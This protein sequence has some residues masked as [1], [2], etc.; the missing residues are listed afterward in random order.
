MKRMTWVLAIILALIV[1]TPCTASHIVAGEYDLIRRE[2][3]WEASGDYDIVDWLGVGYSLRC[4]CPGYCWKTIIPSWFPHRQDYSV[5]AEAR[6]G[7]WSIRLTDWCN[8]WLAQSDV[9]WWEDTHGLTVRV[10]WR[11][12]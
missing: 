9:P 8:H 2:W 10:Q 7:D 6:Y 12:R 4:M 11:W 5:W 1:A 3:V